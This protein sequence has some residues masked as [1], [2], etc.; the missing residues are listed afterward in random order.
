MINWWLI[1]DGWLIDDWLMDDWLMIE[2]WLNDDWLIGDWLMIIWWLIDDWL[3]INWWLIGWWFIDDWLMIDWW[4]IDDWL[5]INGMALSQFWLCLV[6]MWMILWAY[7]VTT[8]IWEPIIAW[9]CQCF[10]KFMTSWFCITLVH[11]RLSVT[12]KVT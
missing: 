7:I 11:L 8:D 5:M 12:K 1:D 2:W 4:L 3:M 6:L 10:T 9:I